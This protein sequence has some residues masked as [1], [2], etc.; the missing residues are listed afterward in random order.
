MNDTRARPPSVR[1][2]RAHVP[3]GPE[4][5]GYEG[6]YVAGGQSDPTIPRVVSLQ[7]LVGRVQYRGW[8]HRTT[9]GFSPFVGT[10]L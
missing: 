10:V 6:I 3:A 4:Q 8:R 7:P 2:Q 5:R 9:T 1:K